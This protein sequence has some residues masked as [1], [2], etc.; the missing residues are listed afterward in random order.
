MV[1]CFSDVID[2][3]VFALNQPAAA[4]LLR[5]FL[6]SCTQEVNI[7]VS[8]LALA[9]SLAEQ[10]ARDT[11]MQRDDSKVSMRTFVDM[12]VFLTTSLASRRQL[13]HSR[14]TTAAAPHPRDVA[15]VSDSGILETAR[16]HGETTQLQPLPGPQNLSNAYTGEVYQA[17]PEV[18]TLLQANCCT[19]LLWLCQSA[20]SFIC[21]PLLC[22]RTV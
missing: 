9:N 12:S 7:S 10:P 17:F 5:C 14:E 1:D 2:F 3:H 11:H 21:K 18:L 4:E 6:S 20:G 8:K 16:M 19:W 22:Y 15:N 13:S